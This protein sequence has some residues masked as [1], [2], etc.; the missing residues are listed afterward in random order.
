MIETTNP[1]L[2]QVA[3]PSIPHYVVDRGLDVVNPLHHIPFV[4]QLY[5]AISGD[6]IS[7]EASFTGGFLYGGPLGALGATA[8]LI[9]GG[10]LGDW[11]EKTDTSAAFHTN[12]GG[13]TPRY[14]R[15]DM[16]DPWRFND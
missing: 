10:A 4:G 16:T 8:S 13:D 14:P 15:I 6:E 11:S 5:R 12:A 9:I 2:Y 7:P 3:Q 1:S